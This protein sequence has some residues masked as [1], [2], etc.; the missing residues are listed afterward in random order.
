[1]LETQA[2]TGEFVDIGRRPLDFGT[3]DPD[4]VAVHVI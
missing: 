3:I 1:M 2:L 4:R